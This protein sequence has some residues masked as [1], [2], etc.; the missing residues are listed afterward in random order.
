MTGFILKDLYIIRKRLVLNTVFCMVM[1]ILL[2]IV[3]ALIR[4][5]IPAEDLNVLALAAAVTVAVFFF[6]IF[7]T[8]ECDI[9]FTDERRKWNAYS[10]AS[11]A[12]VKAVVG[13]KYT[14]CFIISFACYLICRLNDIILSLIFDRTLQLSVFYLGLVF[15]VSFLMAFQLFFGIRFGA[16]Y[17]TNI[18]IALFVGVIVL[19][20]VYALFGDVEWVMREG[21]AR[22]SM[23][24]LLEH[25]DDAGVKEYLAKLSGGI[26]AVL[27]LIPHCIV[28]LYYISYRLSCNVYTRGTENY[29]K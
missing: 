4:K 11:E 25:M 28:A 22:D 14:L 12:G 21:G 6:T 3:A 27:S 24:Y 15:A 1:M 29:E 23:R 10:A 9:M 18:R 13:A 2:D 19:G 7:Y 26:A 16:R 8:V 20:S 17:G 5:E